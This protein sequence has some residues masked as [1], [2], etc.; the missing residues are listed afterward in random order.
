ML[1]W[2]IVTILPNKLMFKIYQIMVKIFYYVLSLLKYLIVFII[3]GTEPEV[4]PS[5]STTSTLNSVSAIPQSSNQ[6]IDLSH[7]RS[8]S[9]PDM[10][11]LQSGI[12]IES[13]ETEDHP[14]TLAVNTIN[15]EAEI[16]KKIV[17]IKNWSVATYKYTR[18]LTLEK[19]GKSTKTIDSE[20]DLKIAQIRATQRDYLSILRLTRALSLHFIQVVQTQA[21]LAETFAELSQRSPELQ[22]EFFHNSESQRNLTKNGGILLNALNS[23]ISTVD[24]LCNK[25]FNDTLLTIKKYEIARIEFDAYRI[26]LEGTPSTIASP[27]LDN[28]KKNYFKHKESYDKLRTTVAEKLQLL[29]ENRVSS[30]FL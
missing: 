11:I 21:S 27:A 12:N 18:Q 20:M 30:W 13:T 29:D 9:E 8:H 17:T 4:E 25:T 28:A 7:R 24:V 16:F 1:I 2:I 19:L 23:F 26:D 22:H 6:N 5:T 15:A 10:M 3:I 14:T